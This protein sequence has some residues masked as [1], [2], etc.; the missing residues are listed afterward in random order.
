MQTEPVPEI[1]ADDDSVEEIPGRALT[2]E[3]QY[4]VEQYYKHPVESI[5]KIE[6]TAKFL[7]GATAMVSGLFATATK[8]LHESVSP[9]SP[10][11]FLPFAAWILGLV[12]LLAVLHPLGYVAGKKVPAECRAAFVEARDLKY[13][14]LVAGTL[15]FVAGLLLALFPLTVRG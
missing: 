3:E 8:L 13:R 1:A 6:D 15:L 9:G 4:Y 14:R 10:L 7:F 5:R 11:W 2:D 12:A